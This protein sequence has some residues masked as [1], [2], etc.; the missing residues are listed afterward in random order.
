MAYKDIF[1]TARQAKLQPSKETKRGKPPLVVPPRPLGRGSLWAGGG[2]LPLP[3]AP[4][5]RRFLWGA[6]SGCCQALERGVPLLQ[7][8]WA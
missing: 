1:M 2:V 5:Y 8:L 7:A 6:L 3:N 4:H